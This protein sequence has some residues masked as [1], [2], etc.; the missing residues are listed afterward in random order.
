MCSFSYKIVSS[1]I[2][3]FSRPIV[4]YRG[5]NAADEFIRVLQREAEE[6][7]SEFIESPQE[8]EFTEENEVYFECAQ[9]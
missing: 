2:P 7:C 3:D 9:V 4:W 5:E 8:M 1:V 6:L